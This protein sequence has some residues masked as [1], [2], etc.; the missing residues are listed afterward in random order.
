MRAEHLCMS[1]RGAR[2]AGTTTVTSAFRGERGTDA[3]FRA[4]FGRGAAST[5]EESWRTS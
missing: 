5:E 2:A 4:H 1:L 3:G